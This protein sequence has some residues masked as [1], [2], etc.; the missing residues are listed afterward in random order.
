MKRILLA[1]ALSVGLMSGAASWAAPIQ[2]NIPVNSAN[3]WKADAAWAPML[4]LFR[5]QT[6]QWISPQ[7]QVVFNGQPGCEIIPLG[8][9]TI[10]ISAV[11]VPSDGQY[12]LEFLADDF[13]RAHLWKN[14]DPQQDVGG[15]DSKDTYVARSIGLTAGTYAL[16]IEMTELFG[17]VTGVVASLSSAATGQLVRNTVGD[18]NW[19]A[20][21]VPSDT[22]AKDFLPSVALH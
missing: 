1:T 11:T 20:F 17:G 21:E 7:P 16:T 18:A 13:G 6:A 15:L 12:F 14:F 2:C 9:K 8:N 4:G 10:F 5:D 22:T 3:S 19:S